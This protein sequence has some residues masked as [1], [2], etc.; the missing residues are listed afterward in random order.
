MLQFLNEEKISRIITVSSGLWYPL[1]QKHLPPAFINTEKR[2]S[3]FLAQTSHESAEYTRISENLNYSA[4]GL[5]KIFKKYFTEEQAEQYARQ[6]ERIANRVYAN[7]MGNGS[8]SSGDG[9]RFRGHGLIQLTGKNNH[10]AFADFLKIPMNKCLE[11]L[12]TRE[13]A[14][15]SA[16]W[17]WNVNSLN[18]YAD[19]SDVLGSTKVIN[20]G[21]I[22][23]EQ[24]TEE[25]H[26]ILKILS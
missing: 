26:R 6:P 2:V 17:Y 1:L 18:R 14:L 10:Q 7:R 9:W 24:R 23:L 20:G 8:E 13:G 16:V 4:S 12:T 15:H 21:T 19:K 25:F 11:Y 5:R 3:L 22:G